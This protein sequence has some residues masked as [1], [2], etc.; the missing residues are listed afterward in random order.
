MGKPA[1]N[2]S[3]EEQMA[4]A[5]PAFAA[6][7]R[8]WLVIADRLDIGMQGQTLSLDVRIASFPTARD[9]SIRFIATQAAAIPFPPAARR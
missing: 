9:G 5:H 7:C 3:N 4:K 2:V 6:F 1:A 8:A